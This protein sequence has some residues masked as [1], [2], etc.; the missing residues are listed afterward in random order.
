M[1]AELPA[2]ASVLDLPEGKYTIGSTWVIS[3]AVITIR[4]AGMGK[5]LLVR[6]DSF[7]GALIHMN[8]E[9]ST[10]TNLTIDGNCP[11]PGHKTG[12]E[13]GMHR[14]K[15]VAE[16]VE[17][18]NFCHIGIG[19]GASEC[20]VTRCVITGVR[21]PAIPSIG[22]WHDAGKEPTNAVITIDHN[23]VTNN[24]INGIYCTGGKIVISHNQLLRNHCQTI[25]SGGGQIDVGNVRTTNT[26]AVITDNTIVDGGGT[27][28]AGIELGGGT[29]YVAANTIRNHAVCATGIAVNAKS[30]IIGNIISNSG[31]NT[32]HALRCGIVVQ[33]G[34]TGFQI[35][36]NRIFDDQRVKTQTWGIQIK[37]GCDQFEV[38]NNDLRGNLYP[39]GLL[40]QS[41]AHNGVIAGNL[42]PDANR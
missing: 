26:N 7:R 1:I 3:R 23:L 38:K 2:D 16:M 6:S 12:G 40:N 36:N 31:Q 22:I 9:G 17:V 29:F 28:T 42:P 20:R 14:P 19:I 18:K 8:G 5:T 11:G 39:K 30:T 37:P 27:R 25:P 21:D 10:I 33:A 15:Q 24:G 32:A 34:A 35:D 41:K 4:G 13:L